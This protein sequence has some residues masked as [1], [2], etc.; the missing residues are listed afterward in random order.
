M[1]RIFNLEEKVNSMSSNKV[2]FKKILIF[3]EG[4]FARR[5]YQKLGVIN[6]FTVLIVPDLSS[7]QR[8]LSQ[9]FDTV[10]LLSET[11]INHKNKIYELIFSFNQE[12][13]IID[14]ISYTSFSCPFKFDCQ[15]CK[16]YNISYVNKP[17]DYEILFYLLT[18]FKKNICPDIAYKNTLESIHKFPL[19]KEVTNEELFKIKQSKFLIK[20]YKKGNII[21][22]EN[23]QND[24]FY[25]LVSGNIK[26]FSIKFNHNKLISK[27]LYAPSFVSENDSLYNNTFTYSAEAVNDAILILFPIQELYPIIIKSNTLLI[28]FTELLLEDL[29]EKNFILKFYSLNSTQKVLYTLYKYPYILHYKK[30]IEIAEELNMAPET[31]SRALKDLKESNILNDNFCLTN[32]NDIKKEI[33]NWRI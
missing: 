23:S 21:F 7:L 16:N 15:S 33:L 5:V 14:Y 10:I 22:Y 11:N 8:V 27:K 12:Q 18:D 25:Y 4:K 17:L 31:L 26:L 20:T 13:K 19:F 32:K 6:V 29:D 2:N 24:Y 30:M 1:S 28:S 9:K 3:G